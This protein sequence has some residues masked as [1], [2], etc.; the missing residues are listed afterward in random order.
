V[1]LLLQ[2][3]IHLRFGDGSQ[4]AP[5]V[6][7]DSGT[8]TVFGTPIPANRFMLA[9]I[10]GAVAV[11]L[12]LVY[13]RTRFGLATRA[14]AESEAAAGLVGLNA[15]RLSQVNP[16]VAV[17]LVGALGVLVAPISELNLG[18]I[19]QSVVPALG[20]ALLARFTSFGIA[21]VA[22]LGMGIIQS[23]TTY[24]ETKPWFP[25]THGAAWPGVPELIFF[26][27]IAVALFW[28]GRQLPTRGAVAERRLPP[29]PAAARIAWPVAVAT[30]ACAV[31]LVV[32]PFALRQALIFSLIGTVCLA[33]VVI[34]SQVSLAQLALAGV[35]GLV[36][37]KL[38]VHVGIAFPFGPVLAVTGATAFGLLTAIS[39]LRVRGVSLAIVTLAA[40]VAIESFGF[41]NAGWGGG[42]RRWSRRPAFS[43]WGWA[44][45][46]TSPDGMATCRAPCSGSCAW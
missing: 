7:P 19:T 41:D 46:P 12:G 26:V 10:V 2:A 4:S 8:V 37:S 44:P 14:A 11:A 5:A 3:I 36:L 25:T 20:A 6:L 22:G 38:A 15:N 29:A 27:V 18:A 23:L 34:T 35:A 40:A 39:A 30:P 43:A 42:R 1:L 17:V 21:C 45:T 24:L 33:L 16:V 28:R 9:G 31:A 32:L 13:R